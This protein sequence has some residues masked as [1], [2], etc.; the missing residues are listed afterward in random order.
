MAPPARSK[1]TAPAAE[2]DWS[3]IEP[4]AAAA[5][6]DWSKVE[7]IVAASEP[8]W[9][10]VEP[11]APLTA[12]ELQADRPP[13]KPADDMAL[14]GGLVNAA[15][16]KT[17]V[18]QWFDE[19]A[20]AI[21]RGGQSMIQ[22]ALGFELFG[23]GRALEQVRA[24]VTP[25]IAENNP[26]ARARLKAAYSDYFETLTKIDAS[27]SLQAE[28]VKSD[29]KR[30]LDAISAD[31]SLGYLET[32]GK[33][34][35]AVGE[36]PTG[37]VADITLENGPMMLEMIL[38]AMLTGGAG[39]VA[40]AATA[41]GVSAVN[42][43][44]SDYIDLRARGLQHAEA[45]QQAG[46]ATG[47]IA[48]MDA[49]SFKA[50]GTAF[51]KILKAEPLRKLST[52]VTGT[53]VQGTL[54]AGGEALRQL[55][56]EAAN[57]GTDQAG[58]F[59]SFPD[60]GAEALG[61]VAG[62]FT[63]GGPQHRPGRGAGEPPA[64]APPPPA[65]V[66]PV[67]GEPAPAPSPAAVQPQDIAG[68][69]VFGPVEPAAPAPP[70]PAVDP[71]A[72]TQE[73]PTIE[74]VPAPPVIDPVPDSE[75]VQVAPEAAQPEPVKAETPPESVALP[76]P[77]AEAPISTGRADD[78]GEGWGA[79][80]GSISEGT[81]S[82]LL[83][84]SQG[85]YFWGDR[86]LESKRDV[87]RV[88]GG[89]HKDFE[90]AKFASTKEAR[91]AAEATTATEPTAEAPVV[92][93]DAAAGA[94]ERLKKRLKPAEPAP[95]AAAPPEDAADLQA[96]KDE[97][98]WDEVGGRIIRKT[99]DFNSPD[100]N[101]VVGRTKH[102]G[103]EVWMNRPRGG[104]SRPGQ[105][106]G[107]FELSEKQAKAAVDKAVAGQKLNPA[108][109]RFIDHARRHLRGENDYQQ[110]D[111]EPPPV[112]DT[113]FRDALVDNDPVSNRF[114]GL[115]VEASKY[116]DQEEIETALDTGSDDAA[117][118]NIRA[119]IERGKANAPA[120]EARAEKPE[121]VPAPRED[122]AGEGQAALQAPDELKL[123]TQTEAS[124]AADAERAAS[125][126]TA[127]TQRRA[128]AEAKAQS[129]KDAGQFD[130]TGLESPVGC[131]PRA[132]RPD[133]CRRQAAQR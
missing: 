89:K 26:E 63:E 122:A 92:T 129:E 98:R 88:V 29:S 128:A 38:G 110:G 21:K 7:P 100:Y 39:P 41:G 42:Q 130:L 49:V 76:D 121:A 117:E 25:D 57:Q 108:E 79:S 97:F 24:Q 15:L 47:L 74:E 132:G 52:V 127:E 73:L 102:L 93:D 16:E 78:S 64:G 131:E 20:G 18:R 126:A 62:V 116:A 124:A 133:Q 114:A 82:T 32:A 71:L 33:W 50:A 51:E 31:P 6:P 69:D 59:F 113:D 72:E 10:A 30:K 19:R 87:G 5:D 67:T 55:S 96:L 101:T 35:K 28:T 60:M 12:P 81:K 125:A 111:Y 80:R 23:R 120:E 46:V 17:G 9:N 107:Q 13:G 65:P 61:E 3:T 58:T 34:L 48:A 53:A 4:V 44:P 70:E 54:G 68:E 83:V 1:A 11:L 36:D 99:E 2:P 86:T 56:L 84:D 94:R 123:T 112:D 40:M 90:P 43:F 109:Q 22:T 85:N 104:G 115:I 14:Q 118:A 106:N 27:R 37:T 119:L 105:P 75:P 8:D 77:P 103:P 91:A 45:W 95:A 66:D